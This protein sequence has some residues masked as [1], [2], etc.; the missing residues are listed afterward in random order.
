MQNRRSKCHLQQ[1]DSE[2]RPIGFTSSVFPGGPPPSYRSS[3]IA[4]DCSLFSSAESSSGAATTPT[5]IRRNS[6]TN[7]IQS[8]ENVQR[9]D[10]IP[11]C[12]SHCTTTITDTSNRPSKIVHGNSYQSLEKYNLSGRYAKYFTPFYLLNAAGDPIAVSKLELIRYGSQ[13]KLNDAERPTSDYLTHNPSSKL[14]SCMKG[15]KRKFC[16]F[17]IFL[18]IIAICITIAILL[19][20]SKFPHEMQKFSWLPPLAF[21]NE[22]KNPTTIQMYQ[23][24][25]QMRFEISGNHPLKNDYIAVYDF[26]TRKIGIIDSTLKNNGK[27][28]V[29]FVMDMNMSTVPDKYALK[30]GAQNAI[31]R[32]EQT[33]GWEEAWNYIPSSY[34]GNI[35]E[36][37]APPILECDGARWITLKYTKSNQKGQKCSDCYD[38]CLPELGLARDRLRGE[39]FLNIIHRNCFYLFVPEWRSFAAAYKENEPDS[40]NHEGRNHEDDDNG[41]NDN[42]NGDNSGENGFRKSLSAVENAIGGIVQPITNQYRNFESKWISL[43]QV[44]GQIS[45]LTSQTLDQM[46]N[47][48]S[49]VQSSISNAAQ[50]IFGKRDNYQQQSDI[51]E[52]GLDKNKLP[53]NRFDKFNNNFNNNNNNNH[54]SNGFDNVPN[55]N[56]YGNNGYSSNS[57]GNI[58]LLFSM[59]PP[60]YPAKPM[61]QWSPSLLSSSS[62]S[63]HGNSYSEGILNS[64]FGNEHGQQQQHGN[65]GDRNNNNDQFALHS[66]YGEQLNEY[67]SQFSSGH[68]LPN[69]LPNTMR[70][71]KLSNKPQSVYDQPAIQS[72][73]NYMH[74]T[75]DVKQDKSHINDEMKQQNQQLR[76]EQGWITVG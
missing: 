31:K 15:P 63:D 16:S 34:F 24:E 75:T 1:L 47:V 70:I 62:S 42:Y 41:D 39:T 53:L 35:Q 36:L 46:S 6:W 25:H 56:G 72:H 7:L 9:K 59:P 33:Q 11:F 57:N 45:N 49:D 43:Q 76:N 21:R 19:S 18:L 32:N 3:T 17:V 55:T 14:R 13:C 38:F 30:I 44:P 10:L 60:S 8:D 64:Y 66:N 68:S 28:V 37:F 69:V 51:E 50:N 58:K 52:N 48:A 73:G 71:D 74:L 4:D 22:Q 29:C 5:I 54:D 40:M 2:P 20:R 27:Y 23:N 12:Q 67:S 26:V 61:Q 65:F